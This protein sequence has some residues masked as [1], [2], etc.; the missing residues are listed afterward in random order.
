MQTS[1]TTLL[2]LRPSRVVV[3]GHYVAIVLLLLLT[4]AFWFFNYLVPAVPIQRGLFATGVSAFLIFLAFVLWIR[5]ELKRASTKY[6]ITDFRVIRKDGILR[7]TETI[8]PYRQLERVQVTQG[9]LDRVLGIGTLVIDTGE[10]KMLISSVRNPEKV[11]RAIMGR[12][13]PLQTR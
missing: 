12:M 4:V 13:Q 6:L 1:E 9:I 10:D 5:A 8:V 2:S 7:R 3:L 11:E